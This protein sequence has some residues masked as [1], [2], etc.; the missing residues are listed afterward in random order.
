MFRYTGRQYEACAPQALFFFPEGRFWIVMAGCCNISMG[1]LRT[2]GVRR[3][4]STLRK[5]SAV[6]DSNF[7]GA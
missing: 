7:Q 2:I 6:H 1:T 5:T 3:M 4:Q